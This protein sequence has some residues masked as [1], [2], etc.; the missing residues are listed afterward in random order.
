MKT[1]A[2]DSTQYEEREKTGLL[3]C[4]ANYKYFCE[5]ITIKKQNIL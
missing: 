3:G 5:S 1:Q 2:N 4:F